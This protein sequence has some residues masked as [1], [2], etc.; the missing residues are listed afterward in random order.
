VAGPRE[1]FRAKIHRAMQLGLRGEA[2]KE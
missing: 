1:E 2:G